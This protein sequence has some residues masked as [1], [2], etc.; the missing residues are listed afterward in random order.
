MEIEPRI[1]VQPTTLLAYRPS[2]DELSRLEELAWDRH[3]LT[4]LTASA[5]YLGRTSI[6]EQL[7]DT[8]FLIDTAEVRA[9]ARDVLGREPEQLVAVTAEYPFDWDRNPKGV[10]DAICPQLPGYIPG[11]LSFFADERDGSA[12]P[13]VPYL[14]TSFEP[15]G[16]DLF[17][18][19]PASDWSRWQT[20]F[21][22]RTR[23][24]VRRR[25]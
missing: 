17:G 23:H 22:A 13:P 21:E 2:A 9:L 19:L 25:G 4:N 3:Q 1:R 16:L 5:S 7:W 24:L 20:A 15:V 18:I 8:D 11:S 6:A 12:Q 10:L 14:S